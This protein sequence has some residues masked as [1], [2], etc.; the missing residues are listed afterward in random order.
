MRQD[1]WADADH[2]IEI[3]KEQQAGCETRFTKGGGTHRSNSSERS[4]MTK[5][6]MMKKVLRWAEDRDYMVLACVPMDDREGMLT[7]FAMLIERPAENCH[8]IRYVAWTACIE[9]NGD[10]SVCW[11]HYH[12]ALAPALDSLTMK[13]YRQTQKETA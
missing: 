8:G 4:A 13:V 2:L 5:R 12:N 10:V 7:S 11:G 3:H 6:E 9:G 1:P